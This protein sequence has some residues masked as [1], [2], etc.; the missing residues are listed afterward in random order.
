MRAALC[1]VCRANVNPEIHPNYIG[2]NY[3]IKIP[4]PFRTYFEGNYQ[5][6]FCSKD[7]RSKWFAENGKTDLSVF[8]SEQLIAELGSRDGIAIGKKTDTLGSLPRGHTW[9]IR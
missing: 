1:D 6:D 5:Y 4:E 2:H 9:I 7:C 3:N 8:T